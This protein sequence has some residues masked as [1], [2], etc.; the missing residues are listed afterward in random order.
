MPDVADSREISLDRP[1]DEAFLKHTHRQGQASTYFPAP[2]RSEETAS[3]MSFMLLST[4]GDVL[5][6]PSVQQA[7]RFLEPERSVWLITDWLSAC[8]GRLSKVVCTGLAATQMGLARLDQPTH[9]LDVHA[10][11]TML[12]HE[13]HIV[14]SVSSELVKSRSEVFASSLFAPSGAYLTWL[15]LAEDTADDQG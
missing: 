10:I 1:V 7:Y 6:E 8:A 3:S 9:G 11:V 5:E 14:V 13:E 15:A 4:D 2:T 12:R